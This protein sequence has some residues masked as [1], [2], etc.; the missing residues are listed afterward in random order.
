MKEVD[1][2]N[3]GRENDLIAFLYGE[4]ND[5]ES[6]TFQRHLRDCSSCNAELAAFRNVRES[7]VTWRDESLGVMSSPSTESAVA[8][9]GP[10]KPSA[11]AAL[12]EFFNLAPLWMKGTVAFASIV[13]CLFAGL[14][15]ARW[16]DKPQVMTVANPGNVYSQQ[17]INALVARRVQEELQRQNKAQQP[18][19]PLVVKEASDRISGR[20]LANRGSVAFSVPAE[21]ARRPLSKTEREQLATDLRLISAK[22]DSDLDLLDDR[23]N[24]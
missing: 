3:C 2:S 16:R 14:A 21:K 22:N 6:R 1:A 4:S 10:Q 19:S 12:R 24:K 23:I 15:V 11:L 9:L 18:P 20:R 8:R 5:V 17:E 7:V 13:F